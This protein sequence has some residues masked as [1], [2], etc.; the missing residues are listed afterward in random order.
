VI[1]PYRAAN[2]RTGQSP[3][4][5]IVVEFSTPQGPVQVAMTTNLTHL[6]IER[7]TSELGKFGKQQLP[8]PS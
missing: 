2:M 8:K 4:G 5:L 6:T 3:D 7:L 1:A